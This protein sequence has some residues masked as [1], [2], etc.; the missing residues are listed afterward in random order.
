MRRFFLLLALA[1]LT[2]CKTTKVV[3]DTKQ[4]IE[5]AEKVEEVAT[6]NRSTV[7]DTIFTEIT[8]HVTRKVEERF[9]PTT[10]NL[11]ARTTEEDASR[12]EYQQQIHA[13]EQQID[14]LAAI[15]DASLRDQSKT[16]TKETERTRMPWWLWAM[17]ASACVLAACKIYNIL[18]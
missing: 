12:T 18:R 3:T 10:G 15:I 16:E 7:H 9:D 5:V 14:S 8:E 17:I 11:V 13:L 1:L 6:S 4:D 2:G